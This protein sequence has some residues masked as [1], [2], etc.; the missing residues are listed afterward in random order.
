M[1]RLQH[2]EDKAVTDVAV[3]DKK[4]IPAKE[5]PKLI[6]RIEKE[7]HAAAKVLDFERAAWLRDQ[8]RELRQQ[9]E[10]AK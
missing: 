5:L 2:A 9:Q 3:G 10:A 8:L 7:M 4:A 6:A 1:E